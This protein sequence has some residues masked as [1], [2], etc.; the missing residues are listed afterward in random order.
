MKG[1]EVLL[2]EAG[3]PVT[4]TTVKGGGWMFD[5]EPFGSGGRVNTKSGNPYTAK[6]MAGTSAAVRE[7]V[8]IKIPLDASGESVTLPAQ[9]DR[10]S[11][12]VGEN[13]VT[14]G[15]TGGTGNGLRDRLT[16]AR[17]A[18][19]AACGLARGREVENVG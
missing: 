19:K 12:R 13:A 5:G 14:S 4:L 15:H 18:R 9:G 8:D 11:L 10:G 1:T 7:Q 17:G 6:A 2:F 3:E 16:L